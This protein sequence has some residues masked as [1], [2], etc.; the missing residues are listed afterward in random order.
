M[1]ILKE[2]YEKAYAALWPTDNDHATIDAAFW[3]LHGV[4][5]LHTSLFNPSFAHY[6]PIRDE[7]SFLQEL[8]MIR[9]SSSIGVVVH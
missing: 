3:Q 9:H 8:L 1:Q 4:I 5:T 6:W 7:L 2:Q